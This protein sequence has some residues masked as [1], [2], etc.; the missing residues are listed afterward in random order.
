MFTPRWRSHLSTIIILIIITADVISASDCEKGDVL[1]EARATA[2]RLRKTRAEEEEIARIFMDVRAEGMAHP[3]GAPREPSR[4]NEQQDKC[5]DKH[6]FCN[7]LVC[8]YWWYVWWI[9]YR[10]RKLC[11]SCGNSTWDFFCLLCCVV[12]S[13]RGGWEVTRHYVRPKSIWLLKTA[14]T[15]HLYKDI[16]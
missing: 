7:F 6:G 12:H 2:A 11:S 9:M 15:I 3:G 10:E 1:C 16:S 13:R 4:R 8:G 5:V 14:S